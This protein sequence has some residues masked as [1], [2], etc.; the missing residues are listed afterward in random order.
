MRKAIDAADKQA[1]YN[2]IKKLQT[3]NQILKYQV[4]GYKEVLKY[5]ERRKKK[6]K[7]LFELQERETAGWYNPQK[8]KTAQ[9]RLKQLTEKK[10]TATT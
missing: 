3:E 8:V 10:A 9:E 5:K 4:T 1:T 6:G 2:L 7:P